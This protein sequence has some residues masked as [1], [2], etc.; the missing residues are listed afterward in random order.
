MN[1]KTIYIRDNCYTIIKQQNFEITIEIH[2]GTY[3]QFLTTF[4]VTSIV[5]FLG[6]ENFSFVSCIDNY[7]LTYIFK[8]T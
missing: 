7:R 8:T 3:L 5:G 1:I 4:H 6:F 2:K